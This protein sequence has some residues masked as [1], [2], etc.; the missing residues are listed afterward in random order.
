MHLS[1]SQ[2]TDVLNKVGGSVGFGAAARS[3][4]LFAPDPG[5]PESAERILAHVKCNVGPLQP[6]L[7]V[8]IEG[9][10]VS[11]K[12]GPVATSGIAWCG[13]A[14]GI[15]PAD[16]VGAPPTAE[17]REARSAKEH[18]VIEAVELLR[19]L[20]AHGEVPADDVKNE[21][22]SQGV[23][24]SRGDEAARR[25]R[26]QK[27][28]NGFTGGWTWSLPEAAEGRQS[29]LC[30]DSSDSSGS[31]ANTSKNYEEHE[32]SKECEERRIGEARIFGADLPARDMV[33]APNGTAGA[34]VPPEIEE[35]VWRLEGAEREPGEEG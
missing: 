7:R 24:S 3:V 13:E 30:P 19:E 32:E 21:L 6:A 31:S 2:T 15:S 28:K 10:T 26:V 23:K 33:V 20:L 34:F 8:R 25:L 9:R 1:K 5:A 35:A 27:R 14:P 18:G 11:S 29:H 17:T 12:D 16:L 4:L 22:K